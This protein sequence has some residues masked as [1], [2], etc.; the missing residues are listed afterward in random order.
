MSNTFAVIKISPAAF[1][2]IYNA[3]HAAGYEFQLTH[4]QINMHGIALRRGEETEIKLV[5]NERPD[6]ER[7]TASGT[8]WSGEC[9]HGTGEGSDGKSQKPGLKIS[10]NVFQNKHPKYKRK[11]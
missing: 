11:K 8:L 5:L 10:D 6:Y 1:N 9:P 4:R 7:N 3:M 2:E